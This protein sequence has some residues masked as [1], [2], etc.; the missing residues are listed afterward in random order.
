MKWLLVFVVVITATIGDICKAMGMKRM[1]E[2]DDFRPSALGRLMHSMSRNKLVIASFA[3]M[4]ISFF[5]FIELLAVAPLSFAVPATAANIVLETLLA[6]FILK[7][8]VNRRRWAGVGLIACG[9]V[10]LS[11]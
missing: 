5:A 7:E 3:A 9:V 4:A 6:H 2:I 8:T 10:L 11:Q 1:G